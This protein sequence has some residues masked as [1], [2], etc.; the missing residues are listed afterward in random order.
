MLFFISKTISLI[1]TFSDRFSRYRIVFSKSS[2]C[3]ISSSLKGVPAF[4]AIS[5]FT[6]PGQR[7]VTRMPN[8]ANSRYRDSASPRSA[9]LVEP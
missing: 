2:G 5:V 6:Q 9:N 1:H 4:F 8:G 3:T 7:V